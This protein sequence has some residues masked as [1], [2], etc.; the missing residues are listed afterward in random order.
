MEAC[1]QSRLGGLPP[2]E[3]LQRCSLGAQ[4][5]LLSPSLRSWPRSTR[6]PCSCC[7]SSRP[8]FWMMNSS[9]GSGGSSW[10]GMEGRPRAAWTC[11]S[12]GNGVGA[13]G[14]G[15]QGGGQGL[16]GFHVQ[17]ARPVLGQAYFTSGLVPDTDFGAPDHVPSLGRESLCW[18]RGPVC[19]VMLG[20]VGSKPGSCLCVCL[21][22][23]GRAPCSAL[24]SGQER[25]LRGQALLGEGGAGSWGA[26]PDWEP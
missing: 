19:R 18:S 4:K 10:L 1:E 5:G 12:P 25:W 24:L 7:G 9:S 17:P 23:E 16:L 14:R 11:C 3:A 22:L 6:R 20:L 21:S 13:A 26:Q 2:S 8:S 15:R